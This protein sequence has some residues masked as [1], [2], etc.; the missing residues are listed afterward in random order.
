[1]CNYRFTGSLV[2]VLNVIR[3]CLKVRHSGMDSRQAIL[4]DAFRVNVCLFQTDLCRNLGYR[5]I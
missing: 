1:M 5:D 4:P 3:K 2:L